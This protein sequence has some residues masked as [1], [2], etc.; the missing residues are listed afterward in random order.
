MP[1]NWRLK[2]GSGAGKFKNPVDRSNSLD[3]YF[4][5]APSLVSSRYK[6]AECTLAMRHVQHNTLS[7]IVVSF[8]LEF[9]LRTLGFTDGTVRLAA[10]CTE[11]LTV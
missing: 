6:D 4:C 1:S 3:R 2:H 5:Q 7:T 9:K 10:Y 8:G 11:C